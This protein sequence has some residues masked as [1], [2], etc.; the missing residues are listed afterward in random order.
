[1][2]SENELISGSYNSDRVS[3]ALREGDREKALTIIEQNYGSIARG[4]FENLIKYT[5]MNNDELAR[6]AEKVSDIYD[7]SLEKMEKN[8]QLQEKLAKEIEE[9]ENQADLEAL[10][11]QVEEAKL[12]AEI[13]EQRFKWFEER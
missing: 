10:D 3:R 4:M 1:M 8:E 7:Q 13:R 5:N 6:V 12:K 11:K 9:V 2:A